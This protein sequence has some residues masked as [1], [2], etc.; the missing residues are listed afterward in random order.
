ML[1]VQY[2]NLL[3]EYRNPNHYKGLPDGYVIRPG[4]S[5]NQ[6]QEHYRMIYLNMEMLNNAC[7]V[8]DL[9]DEYYLNANTRIRKFIK[10]R[11]V[12][13]L[14]L[15][16]KK[17]SDI[18]HRIKTTGNNKTRSQ[19]SFQIASP[20][21][22]VAKFIKEVSSKYYSV[23]L[24]SPKNVVKSLYVGK[25]E[26]YWIDDDT[27]EVIPYNLTPEKKKVFLE[28]MQRPEPEYFDE[29]QS[30]ILDDIFRNIQ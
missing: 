12:F 27:G 1:T 23:M 19:L 14:D 2:N 15:I 17:F 16:S 10:R 11:N 13:N 22:A 20:D 9:K 6:K 29:E 5:I 30:K 25:S 28:T 24:S 21:A 7:S 4:I 18:R 8:V 3:H 26:E